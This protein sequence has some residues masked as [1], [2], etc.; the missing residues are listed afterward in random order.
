MAAPT[1]EADREKPVPRSARDD[2][3]VALAAF[4]RREY[5]RLVG[6]LTLY[7]GDRHAAEEL[8]QEAL[9]RACE[10]WPKVRQMQAPGAWVHRVALNLAK[11]R[12]RRGK[13]ELRAYI[14]HGPQ[15][16]A[17]HGGD[18]DE[19]L[20]MRQAVSRLPATQ[21]SVWWPASI[22]GGRSRTRPTGWICPVTQCRRTAA[23]P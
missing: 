18:P 20:T 12:L 8:A 23:G 22:W 7:C 19:A 13:A 6:A 1:E 11:S 4:C 2:G 16:K 17:V 9:V 10:R 15:G 14:R 5:A 21:R 3:D